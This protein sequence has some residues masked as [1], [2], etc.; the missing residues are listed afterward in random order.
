MGIGVGGSGVFV[1]VGNGVL[2]AVGNGMSVVGS[3]IVA[4]DVGMI[5]AALTDIAGGVGSVC[6]ICNTAANTTPAAPITA[7]RIKTHD[8]GC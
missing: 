7:T 1:S 6:H 5:V 3:S 8:G 2:V 4:V